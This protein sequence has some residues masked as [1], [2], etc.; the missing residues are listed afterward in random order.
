MRRGLAILGLAI[1]LVAATL[2][3]YAAKG[4]F[5]ALRDA[6]ALAA[7]ADRLIAR[8]HGAEGLGPGRIEQLLRVEDPNFRAH[9][10]V[11]ISTAGAGMTTVTQ[12]LSK[13]LAFADF[14]PGI[15]KV[16]QSAY[17]MGLEARLSKAQILALHLDTVQLGRGPRGWMKGVFAGSRDVYRRAPAEL[18]DREFLSLVAVMIAPARFDL[19]KPDAALTDRV[20]RIERL[21]AGRCR[22]RN[23]ADVWLEGCAAATDA[24]A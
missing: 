4:Y 17:A 21:L 1:A 24:G 13:R 12:S 5:D 16:R 10:G 22:P 18:T 9:H 19:R 15:G 20:D 3:L 23:A 11:D 7:R 2:G 8:G 14:Q 6:K